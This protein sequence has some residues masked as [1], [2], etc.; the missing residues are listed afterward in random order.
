MADR[1]F[2]INRIRVEVQI[3]QFFNANTHAEQV[4]AY[5]D[6]F[7]QI[8]FEIFQII[9]V[10]L[11]QIRV[12]ISFTHRCTDGILNFFLNQLNNC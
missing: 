9:S 3:F 1:H 10:I 11:Y 12:E 7:C 6:F 4:F 2:T 8:Q 5:D